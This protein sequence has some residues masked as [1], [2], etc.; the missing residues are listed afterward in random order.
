M[1]TCTQQISGEIRLSKP[2]REL[3]TV[4]SGQPVILMVLAEEERKDLNE[5]S[6]QSS[7][8]TIALVFDQA[9]NTPPYFDTVQ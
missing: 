4:A 7:T 9:I 1:Y 6:P 8:A 5:P 2:Y 3:H